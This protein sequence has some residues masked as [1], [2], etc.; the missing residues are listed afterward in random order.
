M[1][2]GL[3]K[4]WWMLWL[5]DEAGNGLLPGTAKLELPG[6]NCK[7]LW[8]V[9]FSP[10]WQQQHFTSLLQHFLWNHYEFSI[11]EMSSLLSDLVEISH[12][13]HKLLRKD[14]QTSFVPQWL[15]NYPSVEQRWI[16]LE[17]G[18]YLDERLT[19]KMY[20]RQPNNIF[21][22]SG[23]CFWIVSTSEA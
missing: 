20:V 15:K 14:S 19:G 11:F 10:L 17:H 6:K 18:Y 21:V 2:W 13:I 5:S 4:G 3:P 23:G 16:C 1:R 8:Y 7:E 12:W 22:C 9:C